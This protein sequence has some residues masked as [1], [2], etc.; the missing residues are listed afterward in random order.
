MTLDQNKKPTDTNRHS[1]VAP[2]FVD[3]ALTSVPVETTVGD[4]TR[5]GSKKGGHTRSIVPT[6]TKR[7]GKCVEALAS[8]AMTASICLTSSLYPPPPPKKRKKFK[9]DMRKIG[10]KTMQRPGERERERKEMED[11]K[12][13]SLVS[14]APIPGG[15]PAA[16]INHLPLSDPL[17]PL[18]T[19]RPPSMKLPRSRRIKASSIP[20]FFELPLVLHLPQALP[21]RPSNARRDLR[22]P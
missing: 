16:V 20:V 5:G 6:K 13:A 11:E 8:S 1:I 22:Q 17:F 4:E 15:S 12:I 3:I 7:G 18:A 2:S 21:A 14:S 9:G 19:R 10:N